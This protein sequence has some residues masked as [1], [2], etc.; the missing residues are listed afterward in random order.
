MAIHV[1]GC[2]PE[3]AEVVCSGI[4]V[5]RADV[6]DLVGRLVDRSLVVVVEGPYGPRYRLLE[7]VA[8]YCLEHLRAAGEFDAVQGRHDG[9][10]AEFVE[11]AAPRL[12]GP[13]Q[14]E[15]LA[16]LDAESGNLRSA[17]DGA[18][19]RA[20]AGLAVR[21]AGG[22]AWYRFLRGRYR[23]AWRALDTA[24]AVEA[25]LDSDS[26]PDSDSRAPAG[27]VDPLRAAAG[28]WRAGF[29]MLIGDGSDL[30]RQSRDALRAYDRIVEGRARAEWFLGLAHLHVGDAD[31]GGELI[32]RALV[33]FRAADDAWGIAAALT[34][35]AKAMMFRGDP[36]AAGAA[37]ED[38]AARFV[39]LGE[40]WGL[41][42]A[43]D[44]LAYVAEVS[45]EYDRAAALHRE[46]LRGAEE[47]GLWTDVS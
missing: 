4:D 12:Y 33:G 47:L 36:A 3:A 24:L 8:A 18:V 15:W 30:V 16:R 10:V 32:E 38:A 27:V 46:G 1:D 7:S 31:A 23:E 35:R 26:D 17:L 9:C 39:A 19:R 41:V 20:D 22:A 43:S 6:L 40:R 37:A 44:Q 13:E 14:R 28:A 42:Q 2:A 34:G 45:G 11:Y 5:A 21:L 25:C 29:A